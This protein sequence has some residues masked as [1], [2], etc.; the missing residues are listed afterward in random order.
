M[1]RRTKTESSQKLI[2]IISTLLERQEKLYRRINDLEDYIDVL[3]TMSF[4]EVD[5]L[6]EEGEVMIEFIPDEKM[7]K[8][9]DEGLTK[10]QKEKI[11][12]I[13]KKK[14]EQQ[15]HSMDEV[16][17]V[18]EKFDSKKN[19]KLNEIAELINKQ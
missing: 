5:T 8:T 4:D 6:M 14:M 19:D 18:F 2:G 15:L 11:E 12:E 10:E 17:K 7:K 9:L 16:L 3:E 1:S 13:K